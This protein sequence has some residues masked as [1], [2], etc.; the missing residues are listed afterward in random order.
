MKVKDLVVELAKCDGEKDVIIF[1][2][3]TFTCYSIIQIDPTEYSTIVYL[4]ASPDR[5]RDRFNKLA[6][7]FDNANDSHAS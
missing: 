7:R 6:E 1:N 3:E 4:D 2:K 5:L